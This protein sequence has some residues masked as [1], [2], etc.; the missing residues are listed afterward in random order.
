VDDQLVSIIKAAEAH[1]VCPPL[2]LVT[3]GG[4]WATG[5]PGSTADF[6]EAMRSPLHQ[7]VE[8][9]LKAR[10]R[11]ERKDIP[12]EAQPIVDEA[13]SAMPPPQG[14]HQPTLT[15]LKARMM[16]SGRDDGME[17]PAIR[18]PVEAV[19]AW[20]IAGAKQVKGGG[21]GWIAGG[22]FPIDP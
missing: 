1:R 9:S 14:D 10:P 11:R 20:W 2:R 18:I 15:L 13:L 3:V 16:W 8:E 5:T 7:H 17:V 12:L 21:G 19:A 6:V 22:I 4:D